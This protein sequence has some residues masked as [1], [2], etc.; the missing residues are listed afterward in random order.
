MHLQTSDKWNPFLTNERYDP[1]S[2]A[3][4]ILFGV[5]KA[6]CREVETTVA[7]PLAFI[8][9]PSDYLQRWRKNQSGFMSLCYAPRFTMF[10]IRRS[11]R[12]DQRQIE[13]RTRE[14]ESSLDT[15]GLDEVGAQY[16][17]DEL[18]HGHPSKLGNQLEAELIIRKLLQLGLMDSCR[19]GPDPLG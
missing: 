5:I 1:S 15:A 13:F 3:Y 6:L 19:V 11:C 2:D 7:N 12:V 8:Q 4:K 16:S 17:I 10:P 9:I 18:Y 14:K